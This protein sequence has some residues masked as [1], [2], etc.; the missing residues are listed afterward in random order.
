MNQSNLKFW[1]KKLKQ[2]EEKDLP[3]A[4]KRINI[5][6]VNDWYQNAEFE[7]SER[8]I[9]IIKARIA[10]IKQVIRKLTSKLK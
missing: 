2:L 3:E 5:V 10:E 4:I 1:Q 8:Q 9:Q 7:D 6:R